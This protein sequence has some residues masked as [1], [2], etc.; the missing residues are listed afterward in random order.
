MEISEN[1][2]LW[3]Q[4][5]QPQLQ[6]IKNKSDWIIIG[7]LHVEAIFD[8]EKNSY[9]LGR[10]TATN[11]D[12]YFNKDFSIQIESSSSMGLPKVQEL[13][14]ELERISSSLGK[15][16]FDMHRNPD[17]SICLAG[18]FDAYL[19]LESNKTIVDFIQELII[20][21]FYDQLYFEKFS[22][23]PRGEYQHGLLG[24]IENFGKISQTHQ[25]SFA[26][27]LI[28]AIKTQKNMKVVEA[29][30]RKKGVKGTIPCLCGSGKIIRKCHNDLFKGL[31]A[32]EKYVR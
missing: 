17:D 8:K 26:P 22:E 7:G 31:W 27:W 32:L 14:G 12:L 19:F 18:T 5:N 25:N 3:L 21:F 1:D 30:T 16:K 23:W 9:K 4:A 28:G 29:L 10:Y 2:E 20:P 24:Q 15:S 6:I 11:E 13:S